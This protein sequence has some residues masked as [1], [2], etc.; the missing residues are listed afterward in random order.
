[1][2]QLTM[3]RVMSVGLF[4]MMLPSLEAVFADQGPYQA[5]GLKIGEV[6]E[7]SAIVWTRLT[8]RSNRNPS[9]GPEVRIEYDREKTEAK[10]RT[11]P[12]KG[13]YFPEGCSV[14]SL[15]EAVPGV[16]GDV[17]VLYRCDGGTWL[18]TPWLRV[19]PLAD[20]TRQFRLSNL[21]PASNYQVRV[22]TRTVE[23]KPGTSLEG[24]F[25]TAPVS[26]LPSPVS[27]AVAT[28]FGND[29]QDTSEGFK[30]YEAISRLDPDFFVHAGDIVY[31]D[32]LAKTLE[33]ARYHWQRTYSWPTN[34]VFHRSITSY[35]I[36]DDHDTW[37]N[38][39]WPTMQTPFM[40]DFTFRQGQAVFLE[41][42]PMGMSTYRSFRWGKDL[43]IWL[44]EGR[45]FRSP[46]TMPDGPAK[47]IWGTEQ[48]NWF[49]KTVMA[50]DATFRVLISPTPIVGPD[51]PAKKD[52]HANAGY[53]HEGKELREFLAQQK[54]VV[55]CGDRHWQY[56]SV[57]PSTGVREYSVGPGSDSH[58]GGWKQEDYF[59]DYHRFLRVSGGFL[60]VNVNRKSGVPEMIL[61]FRDTDG[62]VKHEDLVLQ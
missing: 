8:L 21:R 29:D 19:D 20:F 40:G 26:Q 50:S 34:V 62:N 18:E 42:V 58:A 5:T 1:M 28:C 23:E 4:A 54:M 13:V 12:V 32:Q 45:D 36:K 31:Y 43:Q 57:D 56:Q 11:L 10:P 37:L 52:N 17:R 7:S 6:D 53:S 47:T 22:E 38:D 35:F 60:T 48:K 61:R 41:Q 55:I 2:M 51:R 9:N 44:V 3:I 15:K 16:D 27:F 24:R 49:K 33:L 14:S 39:C 30:L 59:P 25:K 46:L